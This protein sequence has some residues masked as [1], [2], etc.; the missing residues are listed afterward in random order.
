MRQSAPVLPALDQYSHQT[1]DN[2]IFCPSCGEEISL[3]EA[4]QKRYAEKFEKAY[5]QKEQVALALY[6]QKED[7]LAKR[8]LVLERDFAERLQAEKAAIERDLLENFKKV[9]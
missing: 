2:E 6:K 8:S 3:S 9:K 7:I 5:R 4:L 1:P